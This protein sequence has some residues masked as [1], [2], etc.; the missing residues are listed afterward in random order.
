MD[1]VRQPTAGSVVTPTTCSP[2]AAEPEAED[3]AAGEL[4]E[5]SLDTEGTVSLDESWVGRIGATDGLFVTD[6]KQRIRAWSIAAQRLLG[7]SPDEAVGQVCY[8]VVMGRHPDGHP[9]CGTNCPVTR[10]A[11]RGRGTASYPV[12]AVARDGSQRYLDNTVLVLDGP[13]G[14][15]RVV[16]LLRESCET[17]PTRPTNSQHSDDEPLPEL[18]TRRE[19]EVLR[20]FA[21]GATLAEVASELSISLLT[22]RNHATNIQHKLG[23]RSRLNMVLE[24]LRR[25]LV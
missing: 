8:K 16:H 14:S 17:P 6:E 12:T 21:G 23:V 24:G 5:T 9:V 11:R 7:Y 15:F 20:L 25:G 13:R 19:L 2:Q 3:S 22:A 4:D 1:P 10:N 18:L